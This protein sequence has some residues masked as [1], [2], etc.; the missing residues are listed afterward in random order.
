MSV[1]WQGLKSV[2]LCLIHGCFSY[3][4][5]VKNWKNYFLLNI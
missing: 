5:L 3:K 1:L 2:L 4:R